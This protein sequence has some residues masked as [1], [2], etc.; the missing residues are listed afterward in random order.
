MLDTRDFF[1]ETQET[2]TIYVVEQRFVV[3]RGFEYFKS[4]KGKDN[5]LSSDKDVKKN[6]SRVLRW[7]QKN[8]PNIA[9]LVKTI[10]T[11]KSALDI[12]EL[13]T[14]LSKLFTVNEHQAV[15]PEVLDPIIIQ[16]G[17]ISQNILAQL[18]ALHKESILQP[19]IIILL[20]D[21]DFERAK[22]LLSKCPHGMNVKMICNSGKIEFYK[23]INTGANDIEGF[24]DAF[25]RQCFST[26]SRTERGVLLNEEW[27]ED[28]VV[29]RFSPTIFK[30]RTSLLR[31]EKIEVQDDINDII[32]SLENGTWDNYPNSDRLIPSMLCIS[33]LFRIYC[34]DAGGD[35]IYDAWKLAKE[36]DNEVLLAHVY[37]YS[38]F[39]KN[40]P[41]NQRQE[42][43]LKAADVFSKNNIEDHAIYSR[44][45]YLNQQMYNDSL[46]LRPYKELLEEAIYNVPGL[47]GMS[48]IYNNTGVA[49]IYNSRADEAVE[50][51]E[52]GLDYARERNV[53]NLAM[54]SNKLIAKDF[55]MQ[56][57]SEMDIRM[58]LNKL[59]DIMGT[60]R[61]PF[62]S[63][64]I[65][66]NCLTLA[67]KLNPSFGDEIINNYPIIK[68]LNNALTPNQ[69]GSG[70]LHEQLKYIFTKNPN[71]SP[72][73]I[74]VPS[75]MSPISGIR[76][77]YIEKY[78]L[79]PL[80]FHTWL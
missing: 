13:V 56:P 42:M 73:Q 74:Y 16:E 66:M 63:S 24:L 34:L 51:F 36:L 47:V 18:V 43:L 69:M 3:G 21:N 11:T 7:I 52:K 75:Q 33:K 30:I 46:N 4:Y 15:G 28:S 64:N 27:A 23:V 55:A 80:I 12:I 61:Q 41:F 17:N 25:S 44:N 54:Q 78:G 48:Y 60:G 50:I 37:R 67:Y 76:M 58:L 70:S 32:E 26:C 22:K 49:Y 2:F 29:K 6:I 8:T 62:I 77:K 45:N 59:F 72:N 57:V 38:F 39:L 10:L 19:A 14:S 53:P 65:A 68:L 1:R 31:D 79:N 71:F 40:I 5:Y 9:E 20:K 35:D